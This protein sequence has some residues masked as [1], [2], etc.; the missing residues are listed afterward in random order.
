M[1]IHETIKEQ[2]KIALLA[3]DAET[4]K[5]VRN[6]LSAF[7]NEL[8][9]LRKKPQEILPDE[10]ALAVI[11]RLAKQRKD[12]IEQFTAGN[13]MDLVEPEKKELLF[14]EALLPKMMDRGEILKIAQAKKNELNLT[15]KGKV[16]MLTGAVM[17]ELKGKADGNDVKEVIESLFS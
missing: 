2:L 8:V 9:T 7:T 14:L 17:K 13:R 5:A 1:P 11:R 16:G 10:N 12:S 3:K 6:L 4:L 15:D